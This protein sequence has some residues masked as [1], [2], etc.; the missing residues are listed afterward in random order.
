MAVPSFRVQWPTAT[1]DALLL[2]AMDGSSV[3]NPQN[4]E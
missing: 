1:S 2:A 3:F 4:Q